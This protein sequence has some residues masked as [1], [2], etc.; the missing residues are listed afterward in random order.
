MHIYI[1]IYIY[2]FSIV[3]LAESRFKDLVVM[4][5]GRAARQQYGPVAEAQL[6]VDGDPSK[7]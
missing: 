6:A 7:H 5:T 1:Y 2:I 3:H 4:G